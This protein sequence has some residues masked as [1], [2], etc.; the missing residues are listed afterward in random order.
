MSKIPK[1]TSFSPCNISK[2]WARGLSA[3]NWTY[4][5]TNG[6]HLAIF[7]FFR[8]FVW[9]SRKGNSIELLWALRVYRPILL[10]IL[11]RFWVWNLDAAFR[12]TLHFAIT[13]LWRSPRAGRWEMIFFK[14][15]TAH[16]FS[17]WKLHI[18]WFGSTPTSDGPALEAVCAGSASSWLSAED[19]SSVETC[20]SGCNSSSSSSGKGIH[21]FPHS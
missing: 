15:D 16:R 4:I 6:I 2:R 14:S 17:V 18:T 3:A 19:S 1:Y 21:R 9:G 8:T 5:S 7:L 13:D 10:V 11:L 12:K 20:L